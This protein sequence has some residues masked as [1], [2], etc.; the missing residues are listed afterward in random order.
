MQADQIRESLQRI[1]NRLFW[2]NIVPSV[3]ASIISVLALFFAIVNFKEGSFYA[4]ILL[5]FG[6]FCE[7]IYNKQRL[8]SE[9]VV[10]PI[11]W[12]YSIAVN[13]VFLVPYISMLFADDTGVRP[14]AIIGLYPLSFLFVSLYALLEIQKLNKNVESD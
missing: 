7:W 11:G 4:A 13:I 9:Y 6:L 3:V 14:M 12:I 1:A 8:S 5:S 10:K 2:I